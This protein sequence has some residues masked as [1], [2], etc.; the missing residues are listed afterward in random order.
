MYKIIRKIFVGKRV[1]LDDNNFA[2]WSDDEQVVAA[3]VNAN[4]NGDD[5]ALIPSKELRDGAMTRIIYQFGRSTVTTKGR[6]KLFRLLSKK[7]FK[8]PVEILAKGHPSPIKLVKS[9][10]S[11][12]PYRGILLEE[13]YKYLGVSQVTHNNTVYYCLILSK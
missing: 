5:L 13:A 9:A 8:A 2:K 10:L 11:S 12:E 1:E 4:R 6:F 7:G 3:L